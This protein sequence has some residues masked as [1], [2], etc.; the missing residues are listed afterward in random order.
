MPFHDREAQYQPT[1]GFKMVCT[2]D[3]RERGGDLCPAN[4]KLI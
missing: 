3:S 2:G 4:F 1:K